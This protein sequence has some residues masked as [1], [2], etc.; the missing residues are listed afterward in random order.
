MPYKKCLTVVCFI[1]ACFTHASAATYVISPNGNDTTGDGSQANPWKTTTKA[2]T[3]GGG[4]PSSQP[5][6]SGKT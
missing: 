2:F 1:L 6:D 3:Q 5:Q 4:S